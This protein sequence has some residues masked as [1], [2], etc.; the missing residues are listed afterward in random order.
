MKKT[1]YFTLMIFAIILFGTLAGGFYG[2]KVQATPPGAEQI[3]AT[4]IESSF[5]EAL[6][7]VETHYVDEIKHENLTKASI[8]NMLR[9]LDPHSNYFDSK[10]FQELQSEQHSQFFGIGVTIN[11]RNNRVFILSAIKGTP[12][13]QAGL[14]YGDAILKVND[15]PA[16]EWSTQEVLEH[17]RGP[18]GEPVEIEVERAGVPKPLT[19]KIVRDAV[20]LPSIRN[21]YMI[22]PGVGYIALVGGF[23]HTTE[24][25]LLQAMES[26]KS[27]GMKSMVLDLR[28]N[29]GGLLTQAIKVSNVFLQKGQSVVSVKGRDKAIES[30]VYE[31]TNSNP[32]D[33]P[34]VILINRSTASASEIVAGA[35][36]DHD[37]GII[38]GDSSF[39]KGLVQTVFRLPYGSGLTLTTAKYYTPSGRLIQRDYSG[40][41]FYEYY[42]R[43]FKKDGA[44]EPV[45]EKH[46]TDSGRDVYSG[47]GIKPDVEVKLSEFTTIKAKLFNATFAFARELTTGLVPGQS[48]FKI[49]RTTFNHKLTEDE[50]VINDKVVAAFQTFI[51]NKPDFKVTDAQLNENLDYV[52]RRIR[53]EVVTAAYG[54]EVGTQ[55]LLEGDEQTLRAINELPNAKQLA[56][57]R[58]RK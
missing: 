47:G 5:T 51:A 52:K 44:K 46:R 56:E 31:A 30:R 29:P 39:G 12:A 37:R 27:Q 3:R 42:T 10:E 54:T 26:L 28:N 15:K 41:S 38:V 55:V 24:D 53:E 33:I 49:N 20:P 50:Y 34:L 21:S 48:Q 43:H 36:Q 35:V 13:E 17:V 4:D 22:K 57:A 11:R 16:I 6:N 7:I 18:K 25:E 32:E 1:R 45:G 9:T 2:R 40:L 58:N 14:R 23:N 19:F 8:Q